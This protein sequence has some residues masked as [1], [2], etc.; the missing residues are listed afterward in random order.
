MYALVPYLAQPQR[1]KRRG[2]GQR[3]ELGRDRHRANGR[4]VGLDH[5]C[6]LSSLAAS[7]VKLAPVERSAAERR[8]DAG[9]SSEACMVLDVPTGCVG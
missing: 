5:R 6:S 7:S 3:R 4:D 2:A 1:S 8:R 9:M